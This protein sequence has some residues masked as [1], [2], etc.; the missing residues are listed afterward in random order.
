MWTNSAISSPPPPFPMGPR[1]CLPKT[2]D[3]TGKYV[4][5]CNINRNINSV[6]SDLPMYGMVKAC[7][8]LFLMLAYISAYTCL[9]SLD[10]PEQ[11]HYKM[12]GVSEHEVKVHCSSS[13]CSVLWQKTCI[14]TITAVYMKFMSKMILIGNIFVK[15]FNGTFWC[16]LMQP[17]LQN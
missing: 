8:F 2:I 11:A 14:N 5:N 3:A 16:E 4:N 17:D 15:C 10:W 12:Q 6:S 1:C 9:W 7:S 13:R